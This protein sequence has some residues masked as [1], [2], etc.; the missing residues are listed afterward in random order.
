MDPLAELRKITP[1]ISR[2]CY[3]AGT[4]EFLLTSPAAVLGELVAHHTFAVD[5]NQRRAWQAEIEHL[6][7]VATDLPNSFFFL[8]FAIPRMGKRAD[9]VITTRGLV[10]VLEYKVGAGDYE[11]HAIDQVLDYALDLKNF[12]EA[13]HGR[14]IVPVLVATRAP[15]RAIEVQPWADGVMRPVLTNYET[16]LPAL[17]SLLE[18]L[19]SEPIDAEAWARSPYRP[20]PT[21]VEAAQALYRGHNVHEISRSEAGADNLSRTAA[22][23]ATVIEDTK[24]N[25]RKA[26]IFVT[27]VPGSGKTLAGLNI[28]TERKLASQDE[29]AVFLSGN[30]PLVS[31]LREA[32]A[33][34]EVE[35]GKAA[36]N[37]VSKKDAHRHASAFIQNIHHFRDEYVRTLQPPIERVVVFDEA[38]RAWNREQASRFMRDKRGHSEFDMSEPQFLMSVMDR[39]KSWCVVVCLIGGGQEINTGEA[40]LEEWLAAIEHNY[41]NWQIHLSDRLTQADYLGSSD[42]PT[43]LA[44]LHTVQTP[45]LHLAISVRSFRTEALSAFVG[46]IIDGDAKHALSLHRRLANYPLVVARKLE[47]TRDWLRERARGTERIG[48]VA[49]SNA[50]RLK[51]VGI[52]V[53]ATIEPPVWFLADKTDVRSSFSLEDVATEFDIQGLELDWVGMC[54][55]ANFRREGDKWGSYSFRGSRWEHINDRIRAAYLANAYRVL[56]TRARQ[57]MVIYVPLGSAIDET[58]KPNFYDDTYAFLCECGISTLP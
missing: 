5:E 40:G 6:Q 33:I 53:K 55:D 49:S 3:Q 58:R 2:A 46:A 18:N 35:R 34:D 39:H 31:V 56:L 30:G 41:P 11:K 50:I 45:A 15:P 21:I 27:G 16:L 13:S 24:R 37:R 43:A 7:Q 25:Y 57:G 38:Q 28:A 12:H 20:T 23:I 51:P 4:G 1:I 8:E 44:R 32:L 48:L 54:W 47:S 42:V 26:I 22:Y 17:R 19:N 36:G 14:T 10:F 29:H 52:H 9:A